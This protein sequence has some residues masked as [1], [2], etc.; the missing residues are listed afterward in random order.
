MRRVSK[1][2]LIVVMVVPL[3]AAVIVPLIA[4]AF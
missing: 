1:P 3:V 4:R 2:P